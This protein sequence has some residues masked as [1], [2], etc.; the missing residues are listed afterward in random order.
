MLMT[1]P[2]IGLLL[3]ALFCAAPAAAKRLKPAAELV[4]RLGKAGIGVGSLRLQ[5]CKHAPAYCGSL[6]RPLDPEDAVAGTI[7]IGFQFYPHLDSGVPSLETIVATEGGP[8]YSTTDTRHS[9][10]KLFRPLMDR[11]DLLLMDDRGT[12]TSQAVNCHLLQTE[13]NVQPDGVAACGTQMGK[14]AYLY[15]GAFA[16]DDLAALLDGLGI[17]QIDLYGDSYGTYFS[18][19]FAAR[20]PEK[21]RALV[22][23]S[24][25][26]AVGLSPWYPEIAPT[27]RD[28][29]R[30]ACERSRTCRTLPGDS[31]RR[32]E[33]LVA[34]LRRNSFSGRAQDGE[35]KL[36][37]V[38]AN[39]SSLAYL[40]FSNATTLVAYR[41]L[42]AA[43]RAFLEQQDR[44]PLL[45]LL[46]ENQTFGESGG[47]DIA[48]SY[49][50][51]AI[52]LSASC[53]DYPQ[54]YDMKAAVADRSA[55]LKRALAEKQR[56]DPGIYAPFMVDEFNAMPL[57]TSVLGMC[58]SWPQAPA[59]SDPGHP[60][61]PGTG[62]PH[63]PVLVLSGDF[64]PLTPWPQGRAA[65]KLFPN[66]Q[67]VVV[68]NSTH[69]T[70]LSDEDNCGSEIVRNFV[71]RL[72]RGDTSCAS[73]VAEVHLVP[74]FAARAAELDPA[75]AESG[76][77]GTEGDLRIASAAAQTLGD[78]LARWWVNTGGKG[79][80]LR[81]GTFV[82]KTSGSHSLYRF[83]KLRWTED[84]AI[85]GNADWDYDFPGMV[86][87]HLKIKTSA[88][89]KGDLTLTWNSRTA[90]AEAQ[91]TGKLAGREIRALIYA[92]F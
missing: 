10:I 82:Y 92:P 5:R 19:I 44:L 3:L 73:E 80:G 76:N 39:P 35:G 89:E 54:I 58:L 24:A 34:Q 72:D 36:R 46:A 15:G 29:F 27:I 13:P 23:D 87:A 47:S 16:A 49:Y 88:G 8:G 42:D 66:A 67:F 81:G 32:I 18:Q 9:Y 63:V 25:F 1:Q 55:Q 90:D 28:A 30:S 79:V 74:K 68:E 51:A 61:P 40:M 31:P 84:V 21:L 78:A 2:R 65:A 7:K 14:S 60:I 26:P 38:T 71:Q 75:T 77:T 50:S 12:G 59:S 6:S 57:D 91:I 41:E 85:S 64:D 83:K 22:L 53:S 56:Q 37:D 45:R 17:K 69:V 4:P 86:K 48:L 70:A 52:Y 62:Y 11:H 33:E 43:T 20:H